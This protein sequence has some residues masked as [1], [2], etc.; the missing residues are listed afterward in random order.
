MLKK[1]VSSVALAS[2]LFAGQVSLNLGDTFSNKNWN[3]SMVKNT[4][5]YIMLPMDVEYSQLQ[6]SITNDNGV[7]YVYR[8]YQRPDLVNADFGI[9]VLGIVK[10]TKNSIIYAISDNGSIVIKDNFD[11]F[12]SY[13][14]D[15]AND[16]SDESKKNIFLN[17][18][19]P[20]FDKIEA[21][22][23]YLIQVKN[24][25]LNF[26]IQMPNI[27]SVSNMN[28]GNNNSSSQSNDNLITPPSVPNVNATNNN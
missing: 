19:V 10:I 27:S 17:S 5:S 4:T 1:V 16:I 7:I 11:D 23:L 24:M 26:D 6:K 25:D 14:D 8:W 12:K 15:R 9:N 18:Y 13:L 22:K 20:S 3:I 21:N 2:L 28:T